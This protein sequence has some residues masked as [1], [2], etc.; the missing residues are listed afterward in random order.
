MKNNNPQRRLQIKNGHW[1]MKAYSEAKDKWDSFLI[2]NLRVKFC[3]SFVDVTK[4]AGGSSCLYFA[5]TMI[6]VTK[7]VQ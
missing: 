5:A 6:A 3:L 1:E 7:Y 2:L 4:E